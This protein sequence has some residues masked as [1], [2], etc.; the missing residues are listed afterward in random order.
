VTL[1][2]ARTSAAAALTT[3]FSGH[4]PKVYV[5]VHPGAMDEEE[6]RRRFST[7][8][9]VLVAVLGRAE[10][11]IRLAVYVLGRPNGPDLL[12]ILDTVEETLRSLPGVDRAPLDVQTQSLYDAKIGKVGATL[13]AVTTSWPPLAWGDPPTVDSS[14]VGATNT[15]LDGV[16]SACVPGGAGAWLF[17]YTEHERRRLLQTGPLPFVTVT[18]GDGSI[19]TKGASTY[20]FRD[21]QDNL[22]KRESRG[23]RSWPVTVEFWARSEAEADEALLAFVGE[24][25]REWVYLDQSQPVKVR[26]VSAQYKESHG[27]YVAGA[28]VEMNGVLAGPAEQVPVFRDADTNPDE[29]GT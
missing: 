11:G 4:H 9:A 29:G 24:L 14:L 15:F 1:T 5:D 20:K 7:L 26:K 27:A 16:L 10:D 21:E 22:W 25:P 3:A 17:G 13:W 18:H 19:T 6:I 8:P 2:E 12:P 28:E 23:L